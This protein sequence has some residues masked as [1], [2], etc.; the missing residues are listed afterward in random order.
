MSRQIVSSIC[1]HSEEENTDTSRNSRCY[2]SSEAF[3]DGRFEL[4]TQHELHI[5]FMIDIPLVE[6][7]MSPLYGSLGRENQELLFGEDSTSCEHEHCGLSTSEPH[8]HQF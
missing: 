5:N 2:L 8:L 3:C 6:Q 1:L 4:V 7:I